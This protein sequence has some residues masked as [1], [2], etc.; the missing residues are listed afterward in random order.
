MG[1]MKGRF[2]W[3]TLAAT[4]AVLVTAGVLFGRIGVGIA[5]LGLL[6]V[7]IG[8]TAVIALRAKE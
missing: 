1:V 5:M 7:L 6:A 8:S 4:L 3:T 2:F